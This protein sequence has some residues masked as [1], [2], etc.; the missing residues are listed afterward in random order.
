[1]EERLASVETQRQAKEFALSKLQSEYEEM[2]HVAAQAQM[3]VE[4]YKTL[5][6]APATRFDSNSD[7]ENH[8]D[9]G[10]T[11][12][13]TLNFG[14]SHKF[15]KTTQFLR[16]HQ[17]SRHQ[18]PQSTSNGSLDAEATQ[19]ERQQHDRQ[20]AKADSNVAALE[21]MKRKMASDIRHQIEMTKYVCH[22]CAYNAQHGSP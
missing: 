17:P 12:H 21:E 1:M 3:R 14:T 18:Q 6:A 5:S 11:K 20:H 15:P 10:R 9:F 16:D 7:Q 19:H 2:R 22:T 4:K 13:Q 8:S